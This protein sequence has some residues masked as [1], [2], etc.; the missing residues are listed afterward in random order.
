MGQ[1]GSAPKS[2]EGG[3]VCWR[4]GEERREG[5]C[6]QEGHCGTTGGRE[7][8]GAAE[9][10]TW[11]VN[12]ILLA[13]KLVEAPGR[14]S[15]LLSPPAPGAERNSRPFRSNSSLEGAAPKG[16]GRGLCSWS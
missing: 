6:R 3:C 9:G 16:R 8:L 2:G 1:E 14:S 13:R 7:R 5:W 4:G 12:L 10:G 15:R 11:G